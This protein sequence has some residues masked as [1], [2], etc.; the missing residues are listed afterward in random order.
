MKSTVE[1]VVMSGYSVDLV[2]DNGMLPRDVHFL[3]KPFTIASLSETIR[4]ALDRAT[5]APLVDAAS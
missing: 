2:H 4:A 3:S 1:V 5:T